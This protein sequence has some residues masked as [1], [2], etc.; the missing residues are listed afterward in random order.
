MSTDASVAMSVKDNLSQAVIGMKNSM[1][2]FRSDVTKLEQELK[3]L[4]DI[5]AGTKTRLSAATEEVKAA[6]K[7]YQEL[8]DS[9]DEAQRAA[10]KA[11]WEQAE[12]NLRSLRQ[13]YNLVERQVRATTREFE[14]MSGVAS[15]AQNRAGGSGAGGIMAQLGQAGAWQMLGQTASQWA[16]ALAGSALGSAGGNLFS[17]ALS[18]AGSGAA[19][20]SMIAPGIG[21]AVGAALG[22]AV[23]LLGGAAQNFES[24]D[25]AFKSYVQ[26]AAQG[27]LEAMQT[28]I[29]SGSATAAQRELDAIAF[30]R[31]VTGGEG[32]AAFLSDLRDMA[33]VT[34]FEYSDLTSMAKNLSIGFGSDPRRILSLMEGI[35]NAGATVGASA[36]D[37]QWLAT[38]LSRMQSTDLAQLGEINMFQD[39][40]IDVIGMLAKHY[41]KSEGDIRSMITSGDIAGRDAVDIIQAGLQ[42]FAGAMEQMSRTYSGLQSTLEDA[43]TEMDNA[44]GEGYNETRRQGLQEEIN[45]LSGESGAML[46]EANRAMGAWQAELENSK[47]EYIRNAVDEV[48]NSDEYQR[49][50]DEGSTES[51]A[52]AGRML[53][54]AK[55]RGMN[56]Y[57]ASE[58][59]EL[60]VQYEIALAE[61][62]RDDTRI[63]E[64][65]WNAGLRKG[66]AYS[67]GL[68][69]GGLKDIGAKLAEFDKTTAG[70]A[71]SGTGS[72]FAYGLSR[73][74]YDNYAAILHQGERVLTARQAREMDSGRASGPISVTVTGQWSVRS[75]SDLDAIGL[76]IANALE[77]KLAAG[78]R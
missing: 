71:M 29:T 22:G 38:A 41:G 55:V 42:E 1:T 6:K 31:L 23:G 72:G 60:M 68:A 21:T 78:A 35:G 64:A 59:A 24:K 61:N 20:G 26:E 30:N 45:W 8:G 32:G 63:D 3:K 46:Q 28:S 18:G 52:E 43:Q 51:M 49:L 4:N 76:A 27:Q 53:M 36:N 14:N 37:M 56:E 34:P 39:R 47:E 74:P 19:I 70:Q 75:E 2:A 77:R 16:N 50:M 62:I 65:Y 73:V 25:S 57:N 17:G 67:L 9:V 11:N 66:E 58:G 15:R 44:Y 7:A 69:E 12:S 54:E 33:A 48:L 13:E 10:A 5:Q 40:G